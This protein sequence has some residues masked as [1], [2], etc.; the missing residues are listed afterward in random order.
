[1]KKLT[2]DVHLRIEPAEYKALAKIAK[3]EGQTISYMVR[4]WIKGIINNWKWEESR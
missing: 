4:K 2:E 3:G 1:M